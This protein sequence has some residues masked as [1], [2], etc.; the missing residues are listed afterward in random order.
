MTQRCHNCRC[1]MNNNPTHPDS[2]CTQ[3]T[4]I[5]APLSYTTLTHCSARAGPH[6]YVHTY[7][8]TRPQS[9]YTG[10]YLWPSHSLSKETAKLH[11]LPTTTS[12][13]NFRHA[14]A[15]ATPPNTHQTTHWLTKF[16]FTL[17]DAQKVWWN[18]HTHEIPVP[19]MLCAVD[20]LR[21]MHLTEL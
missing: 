15:C 4:P 7:V 2:S 10:D 21:G 19:P 16:S 12:E 20:T 9:N 8:R 14:T 18:A 11:R 3:H 13:H 6:M 5:E 17:L 1:V